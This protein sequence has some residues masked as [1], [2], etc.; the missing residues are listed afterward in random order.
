MNRTISTIAILA[1]L[2]LAA[3]GSVT[4]SPSPSV[5][6]PNLGNDNLGVTAVALD[7]PASAPTA[8]APT[9]PE[10]GGLLRIQDR[11]NILASPKFVADVANAKAAGADAIQIACMDPLVEIGADLK[12]RPLVEIPSIDLGPV[13]RSCG[14]CVLAAQRKADA[15]RLG[16][17]SILTKV[18]DGRKRLALLARKGLVACAP[19]AK[20]IE[21][22]ALNPEQAAADLLRLLKLFGGN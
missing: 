16:G 13:D 19:L 2:T 6:P 1:T 21:M 15:A 12:A 20:D 5:A 4:H 18:A 7:L 22:S 14:W 3:C 9:N 8:G 17:P 10:L 11:L